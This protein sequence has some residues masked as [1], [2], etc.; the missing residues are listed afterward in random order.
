MDGFDYIFTKFF[1][2]I[3]LL[4]VYRQ[5]FVELF[6]FDCRFYSVARTEKFVT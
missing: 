2:L 1:L 5:V 3:V 6:M 4:L